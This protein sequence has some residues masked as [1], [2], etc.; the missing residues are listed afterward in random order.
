MKSFELGYALEEKD[1]FSKEA[2]KQGYQLEFFGENGLGPL[3]MKTEKL[4]LSR[5]GAFPYQKHVGTCVGFGG[6]ILGDNKKTAKYLNSP[7]SDIYHKSKVLYGLY[8]SVKPSQE[9]T[10]VI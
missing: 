9:K 7:E 4:I 8:E 3:S 6:R 5:T 10:V 2:L 1:A